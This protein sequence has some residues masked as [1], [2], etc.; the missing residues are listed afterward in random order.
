MNVQDRTGQV[1]MADPDGFDRKVEPSE[2]YSPRAQP[3]LIVEKPD[4]GA[5]HTKH[6]A[7][8]LVTGERCRLLEDS[9]ETWEDLMKALYDD[10]ALYLAPTRVA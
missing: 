10:G 5:A 9:D 7:I 2:L 4:L 3:C 1:W 6:P 8:D